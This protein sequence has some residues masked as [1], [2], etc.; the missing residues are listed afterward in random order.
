MAV[1]TGTDLSG[2][3][4]WLFQTCKSNLVCLVAAL[5]VF[6]ACSRPV[7]A[8]PRSYLDQ[9]NAEVERGGASVDDSN[10]VEGKAGAPVVDSNDGAGADRGEFEAEMS[11]HHP[12]TFNLYLKLDNAKKQQ[13]LYEYQASGDWGKVTRKVL[14]LL[15]GL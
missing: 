7:D 14:N 10:A 11:K 8:A 9:L 3:R 4:A 15:Y 12:S 13:A 2:A 1:Y 6:G 5:V